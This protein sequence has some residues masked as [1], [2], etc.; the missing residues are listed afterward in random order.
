MNDATKRLMLILSADKS[1]RLNPYKRITKGTTLTV[2]IDGTEKEVIQDTAGK[3]TYLNVNGTDY[4]ITGTLEAGASYESTEWV[5]APP[6]AKK[7]AG[8]KMIPAVDEAGKPVVDE[9]GEPVL[10]EAPKKAKRTK[11]VAAADPAAT[12]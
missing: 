10:V 4:Y 2:T 9:A 1:V 8:P 11:K 5:P 12:E 3:Y 6:K 7:V